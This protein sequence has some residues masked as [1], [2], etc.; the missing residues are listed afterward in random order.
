MDRRSF[1][2]LYAEICVAINRRLSRYALWLLVAE[3]PGGTQAERQ[4]F[5]DDCVT[6]FLALEGESLSPRARRRL[7]R[8]LKAFDP[9]H[10]SPEE[11]LLR[12][13]SEAGQ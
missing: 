3:H 10:P 1:D 11:W 6:K 7:D 4:L 9:R 12:L 5:F 13:Q 8:R 2:F